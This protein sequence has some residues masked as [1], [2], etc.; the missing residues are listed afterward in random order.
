MNKN[1]IIMQGGGFSFIRLL[2]RLPTSSEME[3]IK[4]LGPSRTSAT[5]RPRFINV[6]MVD[7]KTAGIHP[8]FSAQYICKVQ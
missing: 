7:G 5:I 1:N 6:E 8:P 3:Q 2:G 4:L